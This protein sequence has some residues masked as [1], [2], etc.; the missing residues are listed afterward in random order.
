MILCC[1]EAL[2]DMLPH[3]LD[4]GRT[5]FLPVPGG[6]VFNTAIA[7]GRLGAPAGFFSGLSSDLF[8]ERLRDALSA[9]GVDHHFAVTSHR[10]TTLAFVTLVKGEASY[11]FYDENSAGR[12]IC[13]SDLP[14]L[15]EDVQ[16]LFF[17]GISLIG[18]PRGSAYE[19]LMERAAAH[20]LIMLDPN[21]RSGL[22]VDRLAYR[23]R[24]ERMTGLADIVKVSE[25]DMRWLSTDSDFED[26]ARSLVARGPKV[27]LL[28]RSEKGATGYTAAGQRVDVPAE[29]VQ[30]ADTVGAGD[31]FNGGFLVALHEHGR[32]S[33]ETIAQVSADDLR[34][35]LEMGVAVAALTVSRVGPDPPW[36][37]ELIL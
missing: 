28:T 14:V 17:G 20:R 22:I 7:I 6:A 11:T 29:P 23:R 19:R 32:L 30:V 2:I 18:E 10:P 16:A 24:L 21:I 12:M 9:S 26:A 27:V 4:D 37:S 34:A 25:E 13:E 35:A 36:R 8:G 31:A 15:A 5:A 1:G 33:K 3:E